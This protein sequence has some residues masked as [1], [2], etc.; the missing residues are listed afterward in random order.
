MKETFIFENIAESEI[1]VEKIGKEIE[2]IGDQVDVIIEEAETHIKE[3]LERGETE[4]SVISLRPSGSTHSEYELQQQ[5]ELQ[6]ANKRF[7]TLQEEEKQKEGEFNRTAAEFELAKQRTD[8]ARKIACI[9]DV[10]SHNATPKT[11]Q[12]SDETCSPSQLPQ[13]NVPKPSTPLNEMHPNQFP[14][15]LTLNPSALPPAET[16]PI[17]FPPQEASY[18]GAPPPSRDTPYPLPTTLILIP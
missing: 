3:R 12:D 2:E 14:T 6:A 5:S 7:L 10:R 4:S 18:P 13:L 8:E 16:H 9:I 17:H 15:Q 1:E 11:V